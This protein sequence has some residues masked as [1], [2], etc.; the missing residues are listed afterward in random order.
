MPSGKSPSSGTLEPGG[1]P[2]EPSS[3]VH[4]TQ[5]ARLRRAHQRGP[6]MDED[7]E[8]PAAKPKEEVLQPDGDPERRPLAWIAEGERDPSQ[9]GRD[10]DER[11]AV[12][13]A[14]D[15]LVEDDEV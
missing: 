4:E 10:A 12:R 6:R 7:A 13:C 2:H 14:A 8:T 3:L 11:G 5:P 1:R 9:A 15:D